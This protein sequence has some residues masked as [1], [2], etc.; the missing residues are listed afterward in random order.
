[1]T[2]SKFVSLTCNITIIFWIKF[3]DLII[4]NESVCLISEGWVVLC[5]VDLVK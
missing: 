3:V 1:M 2:S 5:W 4:F